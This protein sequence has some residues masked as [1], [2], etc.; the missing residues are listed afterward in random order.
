MKDKKLI[1]AL[2]CLLLIF[3][4]LATYHYTRNSGNSSAEKDL[5]YHDSGGQ[6]EETEPEEL[7]LFVKIFNLLQN[8]YLEKVPPEVMIKGAIDGMI[9]S[10]GDPY[11]YF[12]DKD[13][14]EN[15][16]IQTTG[17][18][19]GIG[20]EVT[21][22]DDRV[23]IIAPIKG[24]PG[25]KVGLLPGDQIL[26]LDGNSIE[27]VSLVEAVR[28]IRGAEGTKVA[29]TVKREGLKELLQFDV[30]RENIRLETVHYEVMEG[31]IGYI[32]VTNFDEHTGMYFKKALEKLEEAGIKGLI[33]DF[34]DNPGGL[35]QG[36]IEMAEEIVP[37]GPITYTVDGDGEITRT[38]YSYAKAKDYPTAVLV[39]AY[40]ASTAEIVAGALQDSGGAVLV[41]E[42]TFGKATVQ[43]IEQFYGEDVGLRYT[44]AKYLTPCKNDLSKKGLQPDLFEELPEIF[45]YYRYPFTRDLRRGDY[46]EDV[47]Y[48]QKMMEF[49]G[50]QGGAEG[51]FD[52]KTEENLKGFQKDNGLNPD[53]LF[54]RHT[55]RKLRSRVEEVLLQHDTQLQMA[56]KYMS[57]E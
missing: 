26:A 54:T 4:N 10:L 55:A 53:G 8:R 47:L 25:E 31:N 41:G 9:K 16:F 12:M 44:V 13:E 14:L 21:L 35:L 51:I 45:K 11:T 6:V 48:L 2:V 28:M 39:N 46:G 19:S 34:R 27:G 23:T 49:L 32:I 24:S 18:F 52:D 50:Y 5:F 20:I 1:L 17:T 43:H 33:L 29:L 42:P 56:V 37:S 22:V 36:G 15:L 7:K 57:R 40:T 38:Y 3:S 30:T